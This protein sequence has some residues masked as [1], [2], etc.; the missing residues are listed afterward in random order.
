MHYICINICIVIYVYKLSVS[1]VISHLWYL[2]VPRTYRTVTAVLRYV[3]NCC[4]IS[5]DRLCLPGVKGP[6]TTWSECS[7]T[8]GGGYRSRTRGPIRVHGTAQQFSACNLQPCGK[9]KTTHTV[10]ITGLH[11]ILLFWLFFYLFIFYFRWQP[12][13]SSGSAVESVCDWCCVL[14]WRQHGP[15]QELHTR[16]PVSARQSA[17]GV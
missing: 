5:L 15:Q 11:L 16:L 4:Q 1:F 7:V 12:G 17:T 10:S 6:W 14:Y 3:L 8:C 9:P 2:F 13:L